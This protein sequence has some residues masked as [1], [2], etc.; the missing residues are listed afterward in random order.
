MI[1]IDEQQ[2]LLLADA[3]DKQEAIRQAGQL[4]VTSGC[5]EAGYIASMLNREKVA[6]TFLG[7]GIAIP[8]GLPE[9]RELIRQTGIAV[10]QIPHGITWNPGE[11]VQL[12]VG[13]AA[14][15]DEHIE[16]MKRLTRVLGDKDQVDR[17]TQTTDPR[18]IIEALTGERPAAPVSTAEATDYA[19]RFDTVIQNKTGLHAR[20]ATYFVDLAKH[21]QSDIKVRYGDRSANGK[22]L[23]SLL[24][25]GAE[26]GASIR[27]S[28]QGADAAAALDA[29]QAAI[30]GGLGDEME[31]QPTPQAANVS[32]GWVPQAAGAA[33]AGITA[34]GGLA[35]GPIHQYTHRG[36]V[37]TDHPSDPA[38]EGDAFQNALNA[39]QAELN[40]LYEEVKT[41]L[42]SGK[43]AIFRVHNEFLND[44]GLIQQTIALIYQGH[45]A[46]WAWQHAI[47]ERVSQVQKLDDPILAARAVD[48]SDVG[49][50]V[51]QHL[52]GTQNEQPV[53]PK[54][55]AILVAEDLTPSDTAA[56]DTDVI[57]GLCTA[58]GGPTSHTAIIARSLGIPAI[59][60]AGEAVLDIPG[61]TPAILDGTNGMLYLKA[62][63]ADLQAARAMQ[64]EIL[65]QQ[66]AALSTR[67][68]PATTTDGYR[69]EV[70][71]NINRASEALQ[72]VAAGAEGV[73]LMRT[74]FLFLGRDSAPTEEEQFEAYRD[75]VLALGGRPLII[76]TLDIG[77][78]KQ[79][80]YLN[81]PKEDN[82]F[83]GVR[84]IRLCLARPDLFIP[85]LRAIYRATSYGP[86]SIMFPM[87][88]TLE[89]V[90]QARTYAE[91]VRQDLNAPNVPIGIMI[92]VPSAVIMAD[93]FAQVID[94][95]S[96]GTN[97]LTQ[98]TL[99]MDRLH[100]QL[101]KQADALHP[102]VLRM[103]ERTVQAARAAGKWVGVCG[104]IAGDP[105]GA[106][107]LAGLGVSELSVSVPSIAAV[108]ALIRDMSLVEMQRIA[109][110]AL[111]CRTAAEVRS[112]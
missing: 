48:L 24:Q 57:L 40:T 86:I 64:G 17:L 102:A 90:E 75:M 41:R 88:A 26:H 43:A 34:S 47:N 1:T 101:A 95:F 44:A 66:D 9:D 49:Q 71:A 108:K 8:H 69:V 93:H 15:S 94:F 92:E 53:L 105:K 97:D 19:S 29:L 84:G 23:I 54:A 62:S 63:E 2:I 31:E 11:T 82:S 103:I 45:S 81:L 52:A 46:A 67:F 27:V 96:I 5:I 16:V 112:L 30:A 106:V 4:L 87:I 74:E 58:R 18:D 20:P 107:I 39:A 89:D 36:I 14:K 99:A 21:F 51:L 25:I 61:G 38:V 72:A 13:I 98:Y 111:Q 76:R 55:P 32:Q 12:I 28:A 73:G 50:R 35:I 68:A 59:V 100:P 10:V 42:G 104:G 65:K 83:L 37:V 33:M 77:G 78:D 6:N 79:V 109:Q 85:Q 7:N 70:A 60:G 3:T 22:S 80:P 91:Q 56:L 110:Q